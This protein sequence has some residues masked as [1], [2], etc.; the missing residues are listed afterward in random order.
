MITIPNY[1]TTGFFSPK[2]WSILLLS[3]THLC[4]RGINLPLSTIF[5]F[6]FWSYSDI[7]A[8]GFVQFKITSIS[9]PG[10]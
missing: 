4:V 7:E 1:G 9:H 2:W 8:G 5:I 3:G 6:G 10:F